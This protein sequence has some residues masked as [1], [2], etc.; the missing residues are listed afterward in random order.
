MKLPLLLMFLGLGAATARAAN[1]FPDWV[2]QAAAV[3][4]PS[5]PANTEAVVLLDDRW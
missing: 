1:P 5:Y 2:M 4:V 3:K